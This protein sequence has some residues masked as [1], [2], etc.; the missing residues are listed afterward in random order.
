MNKLSKR[1]WIKSL[2]DEEID[3]NAL[4][5]SLIK[6]LMRSSS[7]RTIGTCLVKKSNIKL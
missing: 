5:K 6:N 4:R 2:L 3:H 7:K 1:T